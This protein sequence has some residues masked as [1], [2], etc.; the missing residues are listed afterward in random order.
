MALF[1]DPTTPTYADNFPTP[2]FDMQGSAPYQRYGKVLSYLE[3]NDGI[4]PF[5]RRFANYNPGSTITRG[6]V[7]K[8][9][10]EAFDIETNTTFTTFD[11]VFVS[12]LEFKYIAE[13][14]NRGVLNTT[15]NSFRPN[16]YATRLEAFLILY[17]ILDQCADCMDNAITSTE[18][19]DSIIAR[20]S[21][22]FDPGNYTPDN[23]GRHPGFSD[24]N[25][26]SYSATGFYL[27]DRGMPLV[28]GHSYN[29]YLTELPDEFFPQ[30]P[31]GEGWVHT[32]NSYIVKVPYA[33]FNNGIGNGE[34]FIA[35]VWSD[36]TMHAYKDDGNV[37][38]EKITQGN[39]DE[40]TWTSG[41][42]YY[43][44]K[45]KNQ[46]EFRF[47]K[48]SGADDAP[49]VLTEIRDRNDNVIGISYEVH[50][51]NGQ[52][53]ARVKEVEGTTNRKLLF[54]YYGSS[55][56][57]SSITDNSIG[58]T[59]QFSFGTPNN[60]DTRLLSFTDADNKLT[61]Y[62]YDE[63]NPNG[64]NLLRVVTLPNGNFITNNYADKKLTSSTTN[65]S[66]TNNTV[67]TD[68]NWNL[69]GSSS[70]ATT[71][72]VNIHDGYS[73]RSY[74][75]A[76]NELGKITDINSPTND[77][78][79]SYNDADNPTL[80]TS[81]T[82]AG[83]TTD[84]VYDNMGNVTDVMQEMNVNHHFEYNN[85]NDITL[86]RNPRQKETEFIYGDG[87]NLTQIDA[88]IGSTIITYYS[89]GLVHEVTNP[90]N[91]TVAYEYDNYGNV[92]KMIAPE[93]ITSTAI[94]DAA[95]RLKEFNNPNGQKSTYDYDNRNLVSDVTHHLPNNSQ[96]Q[97]VNTHYDYDNNG[98]MTKITNA[99]G[100][101][102]TLTYD[103][104]DFLKT[105]TFGTATRAYD[106]DEEGKLRKITKADGTELIYTYYQT[107][108]LL[109]NDGYAAYTYDGKKRLSTVQKDN[110]TI[111]FNY[112]DLNRI[113]STI[114][115]GRTVQYG[116]DKNSNVTQITYP[117]NNLVEYTYDDNDR[118]KT[119]K[120]NGIQQAEY[121]YLLDGRIDHADLANGVTTEY[122]YDAAGRIDSLVT[123]EGANIIAAY[124][125]DL[126]K[127]GNHKL[128]SKTEPFGY[129]S[130]ASST[131]NPT[132]NLDRNEILTG[133]GN[134]FT[135]DNNG[136]MKTVIGN[137]SLNY[138][139][140]AHDMLTAISGDFSAT[141]EYD[142]LGHRRVATRNGV[143][144]KYTLDIL[145]MSR[146]LLEED[147]NGNVQNYYIYGLGMI[148]RVKPNGDTRY[149]HYDF[150]GSTI[151]MTD[152]NGTITHQYAYDEFGRT[153]QSTEEDNNPFQY[154]GGFGVMQEEGGLLFMRARYY[155]MDIGRFLSEDPIWSDN[156]Y[157]Y[158]GNNPI[159]NFDPDGL[160]NKKIFWNKGVR[161]LAIGVVG[162]AIIATAP[163]SAP[164]A[165]IGAISTTLSLSTGV[166]FMVVGAIAEA[167]DK[168]AERSVEMI[169]TN[170]G[171]LGGGL[172]GGF[173]DGSEGYAVGKDIGGLVEATVSI[174]SNPTNFLE[175]IETVDNI[176]SVYESSASLLQTMAKDQSNYGGV[177][178][179][180]MCRDIEIM[181]KEIMCH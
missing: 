161:N 142:G 130:L 145:G 158:A 90:E 151:A 137:K 59:I 62:N 4:S 107:E 42:D 114:Y 30:R 36:G 123:K 43:I 106:Y 44:I 48:I 159:T 167:D 3:Y 170:A 20:D 39:Y 24:A 113:T 45:K 96:Y 147:D 33:A 49:Y 56:K 71:S 11:D 133:A 67:Q 16:E 26:D 104:F 72:Q 89:H 172:I 53:L 46:V 80:P 118:M 32:Y 141:Y 79:I 13:L 140:D 135:H 122:F 37:N 83:L 115:D 76:M 65:N 29:S 69:N 28:F 105:E 148:S 95:S 127:L 171:E 155:D 91:I 1:G 77:A 82:V 121:F 41:G 78:S 9:F 52:L 128:E 7:C 103:Y 85:S 84:Y 34:D 117:N 154:V 181:C 40:M 68:V 22:F 178:E 108:G 60:L 119:V 101:E 58:R 156:L 38:P 157:A 143:T 149:Y 50:N 136:N 164:I 31:L 139:W 134:T 175:G 23:L 93:G 112:D 129:A 19:N 173:I 81:I 27:A 47:E 25:F 174:M 21:F 10:C 150:R 165:A 35:V 162:L 124:G 2:F 5:N 169:P 111:T 163:I 109:E 99:L 120:W 131:D 146:I 73:T 179:E 61:T 87:K 51:Y 97:S 75:Y 126:D 125:F 55:D 92:N 180:V 88:P 177:C 18:V 144:R 54:N 63:Q 70:T 98:N 100:K 66:S 57:I 116:Y 176:V 74:Q 86:Y 64:Y 110:K 168:L 160:F 166:S 94:F 12:D 8:V 102:T 14:E 138:T 152:E 6:Q 153:L 15:N 17:R 132:Y